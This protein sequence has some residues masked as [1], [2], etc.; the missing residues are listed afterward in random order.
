MSAELF[1]EFV[2]T[3]FEGIQ[4]KAAEALD[5][6]RSMVSRICSGTRVITPAIAGR[7]ELLSGGR[8]SKEG[9]IWPQSS[10]QTLGQ[11]ASPAGKRAA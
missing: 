7:A 10:Q 6:S 4:A 1:R 2:D 9:F 5:I 8:Y 11:P 3:V